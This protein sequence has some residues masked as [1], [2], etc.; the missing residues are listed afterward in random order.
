[1]AGTSVPVWSAEEASPSYPEGVLR[2]L[3]RGVANI[4]TCPFE[5]IR[6]PELVGRTE[7]NIAALTKGI[8]V[9]AWRTVVRG[10]V[11][12]VETVTFFVEIP[13]DFQPILQPEFVYSHGDWVE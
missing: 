11:G 9:G 8:A 12:V 2:K 7:G 3:G 1:M 4:I 13:K 5:L 6:T 10:V